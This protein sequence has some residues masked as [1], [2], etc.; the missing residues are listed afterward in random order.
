LIESGCAPGFGAGILA[1]AS[2]QRYPVRLASGV[3]REPSSILSVDRRI[4]EGRSVR[5]A[6]TLFV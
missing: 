4:G 2:D 1:D 3:S 5:A 6:A